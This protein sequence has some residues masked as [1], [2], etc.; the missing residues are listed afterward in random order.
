MLNTRRE[1]LGTTAAGMAGLYLT[2]C[3]S[4]S[5]ATG[6]ASVDVLY[7]WTYV[8]PPGTVANFWRQTKSR[9]KSA[10]AG[11]SID[12]LTEVPVEALFQTVDANNRAKTG[13]DLFVYFS[14]FVTFIQ[15]RGKTIRPLDDLV[16]AEERK[17]W[18]L[19]SAQADDNYWGAPLTLELTVLVIN[20]RHFDKAGIQVDKQFASYDEFID[21]CDR[22]KAAGIMPIEVGTSDGLSAEKWL[23][24]EQLQVCESPAT[25]PRIVIGELVRRRPVLR[26]PARA[27]PRAARQVHASAS[28]PVH[29]DHGGQPIH[30]GRVGG[31]D[32][33][34]LAPGLRSEGGQ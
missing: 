33:H 15:N 28:L 22:L 31:N 6:G 4:D 16:S 14:D 7:D 13:P 2:G 5:T 26:T 8:G 17:H 19:A 18:L 23:M 10:D 1:F 20:R 34:V 9:A 21:A 32:A 27:H 12:R 3:G 25:G 30:E 29:R 11:V 24:F